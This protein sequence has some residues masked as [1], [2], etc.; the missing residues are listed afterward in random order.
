MVIQLS[1]QSTKLACARISDI[2]IEQNKFRK[3]ITAGRK[4][5]NKGGTAFH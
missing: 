3:K 5:T 2:K 4:Q 1:V